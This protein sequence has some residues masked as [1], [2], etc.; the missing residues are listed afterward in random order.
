MGVFEQFPYTNFH[1]VN[2]SWI[3][4]KVRDH[5][6]R[7]QSLE[8]R[9]TTAEEDIDALEGRMDTA[10][11]D[12]DTLEDYVG[13][14]RQRVTNL[15]TRFDNQCPYSV[16]ADAGKV[17]TATGEHT[18]SWQD[19]PKELPASLG[20]AG[21]VLA[22]NSGATGVEWRT[23]LEPIYVDYDAD[24]IPDPVPYIAAFLAGHPVF[25]RNIGTSYTTCIPATM[26]RDSDT[27][28]SITFNDY[29]GIF[30]R[31]IMEESASVGFWQIWLKTLNGTTSWEAL[32]IV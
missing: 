23:A 28:P 31:D 2:L 15:E 14:V 26:V 29:G 8:S 20:T 21:Q 12:I 18:A 22:V 6:T 25:L 11:D 4:E 1:G 13:G 16:A 9:V 17:L 32:A 7:I 27:R 30:S 3:L 10:E 24:N 19:V 5:E